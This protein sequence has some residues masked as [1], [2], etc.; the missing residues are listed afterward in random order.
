[1]YEDPLDDSFNDA[2]DQRDNLSYDDTHCEHGTFVG[3][4]AGP[5]YLCGYCEDGVTVEELNAQ[6]AYWQKLSARYERVNAVWS[7]RLKEYDGEPEGSA[8][9]DSI[10]RLTTWLARREHWR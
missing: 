5:D 3:G 2:D 9:F 8:K 1:M 7:R 4:W 6:R 10:V